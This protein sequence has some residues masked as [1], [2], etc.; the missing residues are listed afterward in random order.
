MALLS[1]PLFLS[2]GFSVAGQYYDELFPKKDGNHASYSCNF[3]VDLRAK[4][5]SLEALP[6]LDQGDTNLCAP[7]A[8]SAMIDAWRTRKKGRPLSPEERT[9]P[10]ALAVEFAAQNDFPYSFP[11]QNSTDPLGREAGR[12]GGITCVFLR[13]AR[14]IGVCT[15]DVLQE[16]RGRSLE[17]I[18]KTDA[19]FQAL[20]DYQRLSPRLRDEKRAKFAERI[21]TVLLML[22]PEMDTQDVPSVRR[23]REEL[24]FFTGDDP[25]VPLSRL[26]FSKCRRKRYSL[27]DLPSC[28]TQ[29]DAGLDAFGWSF[30]HVPYRENRTFLKIRE[31][32]S[33]E[34]PLPLAIA[35]CH[36]VV[37]R[38]RG[39]RPNSILLDGCAQHWSLVIGTRQ[40]D[41]RCQFLLRDTEGG[42]PDQ[43]SSDWEID[44]GDVWIDA[45]TLMRSIYALEWMDEERS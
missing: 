23:I 3:E 37:R 2:V 30:R 38:G 41:G 32:L 40:K 35:Y 21:R 29:L 10:M 20:R 27:H 9:S 19:L 25:Y 31:L 22:P 11:L 4:G 42:K 12:W 45:E 24:A 7:Y 43:V 36:K 28:H 14:E 33:A 5:Q 18:A 13:S 17:A 1:I 8:A 16:T 15:D 34:R 44:R 26:L 6:F 39:Y